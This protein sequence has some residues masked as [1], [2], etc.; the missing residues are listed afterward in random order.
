MTKLSSLYSEVCPFHPNV[1]TPALQRG[2]LSSF[3]LNAVK[4]GQKKL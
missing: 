1:I 2:P 4:V 3:K